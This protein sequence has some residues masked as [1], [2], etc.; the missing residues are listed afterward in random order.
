MKVVGYPDIGGFQQ[1]SPVLRQPIDWIAMIRGAVT[2]RKRTGTFATR[3]FC[4]RDRLKRMGSARVL[5]NWVAVYMLALTGAT[6][7]VA[8][9]SGVVRCCSQGTAEPQNP[10]LQP[11]AGQ[12]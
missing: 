4:G 9:R 2:G 10:A 12:L 1:R 8:A 3:L 5:N 6:I 11:T 7:R